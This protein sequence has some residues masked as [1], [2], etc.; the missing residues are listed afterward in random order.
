MNVTK[1]IIR[2]YIRV[3][4]SGEA[5]PW[6]CLHRMG[7]MNNLGEDEPAV[8]EAYR[9]YS[10]KRD[11]VIKEGGHFNEWNA[12]PKNE[13]L[14]V[15][16]KMEKFINDGVDDE[17]HYNTKMLAE[18]FLASETETR[19]LDVA[20]Y[21]RH[22]MRNGNKVSSYLERV[23]PGF[24]ASDSDFETQRLAHGFSYS[25]I[26][27]IKSG[28]LFAS[29]MLVASPG[30]EYF[31]INDSL[32][33][34]FQIEN[35]TIDYLKEK[36]FK[37]D[38]ISHL[39]E[40]SF[41]HLGKDIAVTESIV[42]NALN[43]RSIGTNI[44]LWGEP[45][46]G[47][48]EL[49]FVLAKKN[50][51]KVISV[52]DSNKASDKENSRSD[53]LVSLRLAQKIFSKND[54]IVLL[55]DEFEDVANRDN[56]NSKSFINRLLETTEIPIFWTTNSIDYVDKASLRRMTFNIKFNLP[57][58]ETRKIIWKKYA[59][60][61]KVEL[62]SDYIEKISENHEMSPSLIHNAMKII[63]SPDIGKD[64]IPHIIES[65]NT[66]VNYGVNPDKANYKKHA[67]DIYSTKFVNANVDIEKLTNQIMKA[68]G[69][70]S[71]CLYG[72]PGTGK[73]EFG[74]YIT[75]MLHQKILY[76]RASDLGSPYVGETE[77]KIAAAFKDATEDKKMLM[78]DEGDSFLRER[79]LAVRSWEVSQVNEMLSQME[80][81]S[82]NFT[83][84][85]NLMD[86][87]DQAALRRFTFKIKFDYLK[88]DQLAGCFY[89]YFGVEAPDKLLRMDKLTPGDFAAIKINADIMDITDAN[90]LCDMLIEEQA[91]KEPNK[92]SK[93]GFMD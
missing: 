71:L 60:Q 66:L 90:E 84:T 12:V 28:S 58:S 63:S 82:C 11:A 68:K 4:R 10:E 85:T 40:E 81:L 92:T 54:R 88:K 62:D 46:T 32:G 30:D 38:I 61:Y 91:L 80:M 49:P 67:S 70:F 52:G 57:T 83:L 26:E 89:H 7:E 47:K 25:D 73:S 14:K 77:I 37:T 45:G 74:K 23:L 8:A 22:K 65:I 13:I 27:E 36:L 29:S 55:F 78:I 93:I 39:E 53:R 69:N 87:I 15:A 76:K 44:F 79:N 64:Y 34:I 6:N 16:K 19:A 51:W 41:S 17:W 42:N 43:N 9:L 86:N 3:L 18:M 48:T 24:S 1:F 31:M 75:K 59:E 50:N 72:P 56:K 2:T 21:L 20:L 5:I 33:D 35:L